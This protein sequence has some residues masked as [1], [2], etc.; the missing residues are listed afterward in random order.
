MTARASPT[1]GRAGPAP[2]PHLPPC[3]PPHPA[4]LPLLSPSPLVCNGLTEGRGNATKSS[5]RAPVAPV[6]VSAPSSPPPQGPRRAHPGQRL[7]FLSA[8]C[9][10]QP[11]ALTH[12]TAPWLGGHNP[13][14]ITGLGVQGRPL[15]SGPASAPR[16]SSRLAQPAPACPAPQGQPG[17]GV[18]QV[19]AWGSRVNSAPASGLCPG[20]SPLSPRE[21]VTQPP[22]GRQACTAA[23]PSFPP[24]PP[25]SAGWHRGRRG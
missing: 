6:L 12:H 14:G 3:T 15:L 19:R 25:S 2:T 20:S 16:P 22:R 8:R 9:R 11:G 24:T 4:Q 17:L 7:V 23:A 1:R 13:P 21:G 10:D 5:E 18:A